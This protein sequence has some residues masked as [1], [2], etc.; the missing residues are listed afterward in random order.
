MQNGNDT[1]LQEVAAEEQAHDVYFNITIYKT[2]A[3]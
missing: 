2:K 3:M 1:S